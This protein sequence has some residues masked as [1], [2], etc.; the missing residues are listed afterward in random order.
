MEKTHN[1]LITVSRQMASGGTY[2]AHAVARKLG[3]RCVDAEILHKTANFLGV[4]TRDAEVREERVSSFIEDIKR[5]CTFGS[6]EAAYMPPP[7]KYVNDAELFEVETRIMREIAANCNAV[8]VGR[9]GF[10]VLKDQSGIVK[11]FI[12]APLTFRMK[13][14]MKTDKFINTDK[15]YSAIK[16][17]DRMKAKFIRQVAG[18]E[19]TDARN[20]HLCINTF[21]TGFDAA[22]DMIIKLVERI[23]Y[24]LE[25]KKG[26]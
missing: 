24:S 26:G 19:W 11:V 9:A 23:R 1:I 5:A 3:F 4:D 7:I 16:E 13:R 6:P 17:S 8:I 22:I 14:V 21:A 10:H 20:Y 18:V 2:I 12:H 15:A 25:L